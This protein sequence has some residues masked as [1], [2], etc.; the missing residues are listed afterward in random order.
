MRLP[1]ALFPREA[2]VKMHYGRSMN[3]PA[4]MQR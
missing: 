2:G 3:A 4:I 1:A